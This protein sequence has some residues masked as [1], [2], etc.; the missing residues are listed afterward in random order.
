MN[1]AM[2]QR[3]GYEAI[4]ETCHRAINGLDGQCPF[5][6]HSKVQQG[7]HLTT[8]I[9][10]PRDGRSY[11]V[12]HSPLV[13]GNGSISKMTIYKDI[14]NIKQMQ[15][16][17]L[18]VKKAE[19]LGL[20]SGG[21]AHEFNNIFSAVI[22][23]TELALDDA[24]SGSLQESNLQ[25][26]LTVSQRAKTL[27]NKICLIS[28]Q[29]GGELAPILASPII[30][31]AVHK[32]TAGIP[33]AIRIR[34]HLDGHAFIRVGPPELELIIENLCRNA[35][36]AMGENGA[37]TVMLGCDR[38]PSQQLHAAPETP[39]E[40][41]IEMSIMD[42]GEGIAPEHLARIFDPFFTT[43]APGRGT[44]LGLAMVQSLVERYGGKIRATSKPG[45]GT[46]I[47]VL[48]PAANIAAEQ[49]A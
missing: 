35:L 33:A 13:R 46:T 1:P 31:K 32:A 30:E 11:L 29:E 43:K 10:S 19:L 8:E 41:F 44:G 14:T 7:A 34:L 16:A 17:L 9:V 38:Q 39:G 28:R 22:G 27:V 18:K 3:V 12:S 2:R 26:V 15:E 47:T 48:W 21:I 6:V 24:I 40:E 45:M 23:F 5:C 49:K 36:E 4:G 42:T 37:L 20:M 25:E